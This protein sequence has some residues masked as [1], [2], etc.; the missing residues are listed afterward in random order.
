MCDILKPPEQAPA[1]RSQFSETG[2]VSAG[3]EA[4]ASLAVIVE[5]GSF[6]EGLESTGIVPDRSYS[7]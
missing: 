5:S 6:S 1:V 3:S 4:T 7:N 2:L